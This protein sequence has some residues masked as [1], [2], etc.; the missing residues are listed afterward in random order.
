MAKQGTL[1]KLAVMTLEELALF[2]W[3]MCAYVHA[4]TEDL[5]FVLLII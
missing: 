3:C 5:G 2:G 4:C 1:H